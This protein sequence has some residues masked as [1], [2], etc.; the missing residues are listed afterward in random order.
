M[1]DRR[2]RRFRDRC[3]CDIPARHGA[4]SSVSLPGPQQGHGERRSRVDK[5]AVLTRAVELNDSAMNRVYIEF[6]LSNDEKRLLAEA[7]E[8][9]TLL[10][11]R[12]TQ[13]PADTSK[14]TVFENGRS[15]RKSTS[16][17]RR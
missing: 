8:L 15:S 5:S 9:A 17:A 4:T 7:V 2:P 14:E 10:R 6:L 1:R 3:P 12:A 16:F 11:R 13:A